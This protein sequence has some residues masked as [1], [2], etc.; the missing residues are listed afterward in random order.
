[1]GCGLVHDHGLCHCANAHH[2]APGDG[3]NAPGAAS[4]Q[5]RRSAWIKVPVGEEAAALSISLPPLGWA[6]VQGSVAL[7]ACGFRADA[8]PALATLLLL[9]G[10][11]RA[12]GE[13]RAGAAPVGAQE[14]GK[15]RCTP[16]PHCHL[17]LALHHRRARHG[18]RRCRPRLPIWNAGKCT[19]APFLPGSTPH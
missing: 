2:A 18:W 9:P 11:R 12:G 19:I 13:A 7:F 8:A 5:A 14:R 6:L 17:R 1:M 16:A 3:C 10:L 15:G 4:V